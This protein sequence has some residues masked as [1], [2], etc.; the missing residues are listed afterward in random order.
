[1]NPES[2]YFSELGSDAVAK[3]M[4]AISAHLSDCFDYEQ[5]SPSGCEAAGGLPESRS[6]DNKAVLI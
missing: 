6:G 2:G 5:D 1:M 4:A 3:F